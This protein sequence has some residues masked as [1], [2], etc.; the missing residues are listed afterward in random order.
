[1]TRSVQGLVLDFYGTIAHDDDELTAAVAERVA[2]ETG[3]DSAVLADLW[4]RSYCQLA[5][6]AHGDAFRTL[7]DLAADS[8]AS[9]LDAVGSGLDARGLIDRL[10]GHW[11]APPPFDDALR[12]LADGATGSG[13]PVVILSD[14]DTADL[15]RA[16]GSLGLEGLPFVTSEAARAYKPRAEGFALALERLGLRP[17]EVVH[18]GDSWGSDVLGAA[19]SGIRPVWL[20]RKGKARPGPAPRGLIELSTLDDLGRALRDGN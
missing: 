19:A 14:V 2:H 6:A 11:S 1:M 5:D 12:L 15:E 9:T 17:H 3:A 20:N 18:V 4:W 16:L 8:L 13:L 7:R 10:R